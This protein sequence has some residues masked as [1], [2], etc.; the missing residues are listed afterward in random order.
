MNYQKFPIRYEK[1]NNKFIFTYFSVLCNFP[2]HLCNN[3]REPIFISICPPYRKIA[4]AAILELICHSVDV[5][6]HIVCTID[7]VDVNANVYNIRT[8]VVWTRDNFVN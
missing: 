7:S 4:E 6:E 5:A 8:H 3:K 1:L 2:V